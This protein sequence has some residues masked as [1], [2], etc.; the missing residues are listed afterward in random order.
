[1]KLREIV[2]DCRLEK[3]F[4]HRPELSA[5]RSSVEKE[6][7]R[8]DRIF[9][10]LTIC[11]ASIE[12]PYRRRYTSSLYCFGIKIEIHG[13][14]L[15]VMR[16]PTSHGEPTEVFTVIRNTFEEVTWKLNEC[17]VARAE[18]D[19]TGSRSRKGFEYPI[20]PNFDRVSAFG[21]C[22]LTGNTTA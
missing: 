2:I 7:E 11:R 8:L 19:S 5:I 18:L 13:R 17:F 12:L 6:I 15:K 1:V 4:Q 3:I 10:E 20:S 9:E 22:A 14:K 16:L 21:S